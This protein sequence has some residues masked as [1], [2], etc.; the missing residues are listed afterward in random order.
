MIQRLGRSGGGLY[1]DCQVAES[2]C[3]FW[4]SGPR[5]F[6]F[7]ARSAAIKRFGL[8]IPS[9]RATKCPQVAYES[10]WVEDNGRCGVEVLWHR[11]TLTYYRSLPFGVSAEI[12]LFRHAPCL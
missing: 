3:L 1:S 11:R 8:F 7:I 2:D 10:E 4:W 5:I 9:L 12:A 6:S